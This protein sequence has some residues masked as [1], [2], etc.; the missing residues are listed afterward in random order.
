MREGTCIFAKDDKQWVIADDPR[1]ADQLWKWVLGDEQ[2][3]SELTDDRSLLCTCLEFYLCRLLEGLEYS[4]TR[5]LWCDGV[6]GLSIEER[7]SLTIG[8]NG[9][10]Y[11][12]QEQRRLTMSP[13]DLAFTF[14]HSQSQVA[15][16]E[17]LH[18]G[19][20]GRNGELTDTKAYAS[21]AEEGYPWAIKVELTPLNE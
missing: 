11:A 19:Q 7:G 9:L 5:G 13:F 12:M 4:R 15:I 6:V 3:R 18:F 14:D 10:A 17:V 16:R 8:V 1:I 2:Q 20:L 21:V